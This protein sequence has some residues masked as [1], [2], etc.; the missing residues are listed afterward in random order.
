[1]N[2]SIPKKFKI[3]VDFDGT[4]TKKDIGE[5]FL[6]TFGDKETHRRAV[7]EWVGRKI[8]SSEVWNIMLKPVVYEEDK[9]KMFLKEAELDSTFKDFVKYAKERGDEIRILSDGLD[10]YINEILSRE[11]L[12]ELELYSNKAIFNGTSVSA[13]FPFQDEECK[14]CGNCKRNHIL[15]YSSDDDFTVYIGDGNSDK[16]PSQYCDYI[17][18]KSSLLKFCEINRIS[19]FPFENFNDI[20]EK[21]ES[22]RYR[23]NLKK[24]CQ[25][26][27]KRKE[28]YELG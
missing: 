10:F 21:L 19:Y 20:I 16:C 12:N 14:L 1:M 22:L 13:V 23:K 27:L 5:A 26:L 8:G 11:G 25:A 6:L 9:F 24:R 17:F 15:L 4:I 2:K 3:F 7:S 28:V 18:A